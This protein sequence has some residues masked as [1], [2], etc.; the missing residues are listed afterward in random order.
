MERKD[1][2][3]RRVAI[4]SFLSDIFLAAAD[5][6]NGSWEQLGWQVACNI[7]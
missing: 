2:G 3:C 4:F 1:G 6:A 7:Q 5:F